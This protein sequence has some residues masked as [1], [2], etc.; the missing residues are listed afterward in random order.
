M[1]ELDF[2]RQ[3]RLVDASG[4]PTRLKISDW[5]TGRLGCPIIALEG[6]NHGTILSAPDDGAVAR[7]SD[8]L[9][10]VKTADGYQTWLTNAL[11]YGKNALAKM[12]EMSKLDGK[13]GAGWQQFVMHV[14]DD[15]GDGVSDYN[16]QLFI[17]DDL[18]QSDDPTYPPVPLIVD[19]YSGDSSYRC[20]YVRLSEDMINVGTN[21]HPKKAWM[22]LIASSGTSYIEYEAYSNPDPGD[23]TAVAKKLKP[24]LGER[25]A[26][27]LDVTELGSGAKLFYPYTTTLIEIVLEREPT[28]LVDVSSLFKFWQ[29]G[30]PG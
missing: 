16:V 15:H 10:N 20:F 6:K 14:K 4:Q 11:A 17:G 12:D 25:N 1:V 29:K 30:E 26:V 18:E 3:P 28:P 9:R 5:V 19:T 7:V 23:R 27:K 2:L 24:E 22:E 21:G 8:F 13:G